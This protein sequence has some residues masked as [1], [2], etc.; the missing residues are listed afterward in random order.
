MIDCDIIILL[1]INDQNELNNITN[2]SNGMMYYMIQHWNWIE[3]NGF[4]GWN[5]K[6]SHVS[7]I[8]D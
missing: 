5:K 7:V 1:N 2:D 8:Y 3:N 6:L 4:M